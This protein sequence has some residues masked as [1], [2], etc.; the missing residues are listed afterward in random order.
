[1][2]QL[3]PCRP[4]ERTHTQQLKIE[5]QKN[6]GDVF[7]LHRPSLRMVISAVRQFRRV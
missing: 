7:F 6:D 3:A 5:E 4:K 1:M 2:F